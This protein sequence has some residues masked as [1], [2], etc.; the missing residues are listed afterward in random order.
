MPARRTAS[1]V[2][3]R[4]PKHSGTL[5]VS[6]ARGI[7]SVYFDARVVGDR[8]DSSFLSL[9]SVPNAAL[10]QA[11]T[12]D[13]TVNPGYTVAGLGVDVRAHRMLTLFVRANNVT[14][15]EYES[16]LGYPGMPRTVMV[17]TR[18]GFGLR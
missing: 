1:R 14:D 17:G 18:F 2:R 11:V 16:A 8:H 3:R 12:T 4:R 6:Y 9:R 5:R 10:P 15:T 7:A 13:I